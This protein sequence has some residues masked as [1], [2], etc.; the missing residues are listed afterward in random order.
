[1]RENVPFSLIAGALRDLLLLF[2]GC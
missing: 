1:M 2:P